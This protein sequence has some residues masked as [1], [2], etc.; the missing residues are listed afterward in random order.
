MVFDLILSFISFLYLYSGIFILT[1]SSFPLY[2]Q[3][4][5]LLYDRSGPISTIKVLFFFDIAVW[6]V[7][8]RN[9]VIHIQRCLDNVCIQNWLKI[10]F[11]NMQS[12]VQRCFYISWWCWGCLLLFIKVGGE[13]R[14]EERRC[15]ASV[16]MLKSWK[17]TVNA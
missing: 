14:G 3:N 1:N 5:E 17:W 8:M 13:G 15:S 2:L 9:Q 11:Q 10:K 12:S 4:K 7:L 6:K 16:Y